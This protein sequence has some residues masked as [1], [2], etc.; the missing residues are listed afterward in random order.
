ML[1]RF[2]ELCCRTYINIMVLVMSSNYAHC[3]KG[4]KC[5]KMFRFL[6]VIMSFVNFTMMIPS[7]GSRFLMLALPFI[8]YIWLVCFSEKKF[9]KYVYILGAMFL[10]LIPMPMQIMQFPCLMYYQ[11]VL[12]PEFYLTSPF[13]LFFKYTIFF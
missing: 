9:R 8:A 11:K 3:I 1:K 5:E 4:T 10:L 13:Y 7:L 6:L 2:L 12:E